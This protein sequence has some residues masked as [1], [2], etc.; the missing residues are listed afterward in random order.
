MYEITDYTKQKAKK[1]FVSV[2][3]STN[4]KKKLD[5]FKDDKKVASIG[6]A[7]MA[8]YP[9]YIKTHGKAYANERRRLYNLRHKNDTGIAGKLA[10]ELLW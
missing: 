8:D 9:T 2:K 6:A 1:L 4:P 5:V 10:R 7:G 3:R